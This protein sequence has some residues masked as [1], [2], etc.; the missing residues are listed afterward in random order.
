MKI[1][2]KYS[3]L[4]ILLLGARNSWSH[5]STSSELNNTS[6]SKSNLE[7]LAQKQQ[8]WI[9]E[10]NREKH[11]QYKEEQ[12]EILD[13]QRDKDFL[14][15]NEY[16]LID[17]K[18]DLWLGFFDGKWDMV[19]DNTYPDIKGDKYLPQQVIRIK[20]GS[21][22]SQFL[23]DSYIGMDSDYPLHCYNKADGVL[24]NSSEYILFYSGCVN[25][26]PE[27]NGRRK[28]SYDIL[29]Y[30][31][32]YDTIVSVNSFDSIKLI[33]SKLY[34]D[35]LKYNNAFFV[36]EKT[37]MSFKIDGKDK[38]IDVDSNSGKPLDVGSDYD[39]IQSFILKRL[40]EKKENNYSD[41]VEDKKNSD[42]RQMK[43][44]YHN[45]Y[46][47]IDKNSNFRIG[48]FDGKSV[49]TDIQLK[50][51]ENRTLS[52][53][54]QVIRIREDDYVYQFLVREEDDENPPSC[55]NWN[56]RVLSNSSKYTY[57][58]YGCTDYKLQA[59]SSRHE[60]VY[61]IFL[62]DKE[63]KTLVNLDSFNYSIPN[64]LKYQKEAFGFKNGYYFYELGAFKITGKD[65]VVIVD[66]DTGNPIP[67]IPEL[68][69]NSKPV[70]VDGKP[71][72][73]ND[74]DGY[75]PRILQRLPEVHVS[76]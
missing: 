3:I 13:E 32:K 37:G 55:L 51:I 1:F 56:G 20:Q 28:I 7:Q 58:Y 22:T 16:W 53:P 40:P 31:K 17:K 68:D 76:N 6:I 11:K 8:Q 24:L 54:Q 60:G 66:Q 18:Q 2:I 19:P 30:S 64:A 27:A 57:F 23:L 26:T 33:D 5:D 4:V 70:L 50:G 12:N 52:R 45:V 59:K 48:I 47:L 14:P 34:S 10:D 69:D 46:T 73:I 49:T 9:D 39:S 41:E 63:L 15:Y 61:Y 65:Q 75:N 62:Y 43:F 67:K 36:Y 42:I 35:Y 71:V 44:I 38:A 29:L 72:M 21:K 74:P 25:V